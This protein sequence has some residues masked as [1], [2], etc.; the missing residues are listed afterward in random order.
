M[1][2][3][4]RHSGREMWGGVGVGWGELVMRWREN[5]KKK[6]GVGRI[7]GDSARWTNV[8]EDAV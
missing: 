8:T 4:R 3:K 1:Q 5:E 2:C 7:P 6:K